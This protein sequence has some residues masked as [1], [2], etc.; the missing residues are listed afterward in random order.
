MSNCSTL[1]TLSLIEHWAHGETSLIIYSF[2]T[3]LDTD[4]DA[5]YDQTI[6]S[7]IVKL[8]ASDDDFYA[9]C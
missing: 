7:S 9:R 2:L 6:Q 5:E 3:S 8:F 1:S 4:F